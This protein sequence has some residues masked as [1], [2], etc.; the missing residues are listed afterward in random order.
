M[1]LVKIPTNATSIRVN[2]RKT[3]NASTL[4][5]VFNVAVILVLAEIQKSFAW[6]WMNADW[7]NTTVAIKLLA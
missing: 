2:V 3:Q 7:V 1:V 4:P 5:A 6:T